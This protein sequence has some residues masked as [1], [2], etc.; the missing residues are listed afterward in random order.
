LSY[1]APD[2][3]V[4]GV[5]DLALVVEHPLSSGLLHAVHV[6]PVPIP[7]YTFDGLNHFLLHV[8][9]PNLNI[10]PH[11]DGVDELDDLFLGTDHAID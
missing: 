9:Q 5:D 7:Y 10:E 3:L 11:T 6:I 2:Y 1:I 8:H 4:A